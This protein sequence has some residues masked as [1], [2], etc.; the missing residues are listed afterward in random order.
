MKKFVL[1]LIIY[2]LIFGILIILPCILLDPYNVFHP[3]HVRDNGVEPNKNYIKMTY[4]LANAQKFDAFMFGSSLTGMI[5]AENIPNVK[6]YNMTHSGGI[7]SETAANLKTM[8][9]AGIIPKEIYLGLESIS[10]S[11]CYENR[12]SNRMRCP[13]EY[14]RTNP[15]EFI[16]LYIDPAV[17]IEAL[18]T[19]LSNDNENNSTVEE[20]FYN[21][22]GYPF[23]GYTWEYD[24]AEADARLNEVTAQY[25]AAVE[26]GE[27][28]AERPQY[29]DEALDSVREIVAL[30]NENNIKLTVFTNPI[31]YE[32]FSD[33]V[34]NLCYLDFLEELAEITPYYNFS[35]FNKYTTDLSC[36]HEDKTHFLVELGD[37]M[38][39]TMCSGKT[40][41]ETLNEGFGTYVTEDNVQELLKILTDIK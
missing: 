26:K 25:T 35:G 39:D 24:M 31:Y 4:I 12:C 29:M 17:N 21:N 27:L 36:Y 38:L 32:T 23:Y 16:S 33:A 19:V 15:L 40:A 9:N 2:I 3:F 34:L 41:P 1:K 20:I 7:A 6:C 37:I 10:Y 28:S 13:Y 11:D 5:N 8:L 22:G 14:S 18:K 30:C